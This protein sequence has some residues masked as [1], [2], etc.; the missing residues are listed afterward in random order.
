MTYNARSRRIIQG[1]IQSKDT[2]IADTIDIISCKAKFEVEANIQFTK[3][4]LMLQLEKKKN[5]TGLHVEELG[6][7]KIVWYY[8]RHLDFCSHFLTAPD[9]YRD[10]RRRG[11]KS[12]LQQKR[13]KK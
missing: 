13:S 5:L 3:D 9:T 11:E 2:R 1:D 7:L 8:H 12:Q 6:V 10:D 4:I